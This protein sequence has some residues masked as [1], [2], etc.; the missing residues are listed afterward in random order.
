MQ[1]VTPSQAGET[2]SMSPEWKR[3]TH[4]HGIC[5]QLLGDE[6]GSTGNRLAMSAVRTRM[7]GIIPNDSC[8]KTFNMPFVGIE[9][10]PV[11]DS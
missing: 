7:Q 11:Y 10:S 6:Q 2:M 4:E 3:R 5:R 1:A 9:D 8:S